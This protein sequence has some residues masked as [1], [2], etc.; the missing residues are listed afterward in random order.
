MSSPAPKIAEFDFLVIGSGPAGQKAAIQAAKPHLP[1][2]LGGSHQFQ[3]GSAQP[4]GHSLQ[5]AASALADRY[6]T[7]PQ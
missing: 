5:A 6:G 3:V 7:A 4:L 2:L 1:V